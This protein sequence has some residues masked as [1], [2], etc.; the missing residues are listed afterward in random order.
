MAT[1]E[2]TPDDLLSSLA[3]PNQTYGGHLGATP[4]AVEGTG[5]KKF[6]RWPSQ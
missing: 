5:L 2:K 3:Y 6:T 4:R 1:I